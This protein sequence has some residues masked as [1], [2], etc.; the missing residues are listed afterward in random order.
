MERCFAAGTDESGVR[1]AVRRNS[2]KSETLGDLS[3]LYY[4]FQTKIGCLGCLFVGKAGDPV[5]KRGA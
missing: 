2:A 4:L 1:I 5:G 3:A